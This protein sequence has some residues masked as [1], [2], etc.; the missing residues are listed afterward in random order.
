MPDFT[1]DKIP[2][3]F[4]RLIDNGFPANKINVGFGK[5]SFS[6]NYID[7]ENYQISI[8][9][10]K[11]AYQ[12]I[13]SKYPDIVGYNINFGLKLKYFL[14]QCYGLLILIQIIFL[15]LKSQM[16]Y[17]WDF[18]KYNLKTK[19]KKKKISNYEKIKN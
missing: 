1:G 15:A 3:Y 2:D 14:E 8:K 17:S 11:S 9:D 7:G 12:T 4:Q 16:I 10:A 18:G 13:K 5:V 6:S 19:F